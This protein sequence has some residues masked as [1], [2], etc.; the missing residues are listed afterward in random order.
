MSAATS[1]T[2]F[3]LARA[4]LRSD[5]LMHVV[6]QRDTG[7]LNPV[8]GAHP[9][10]GKVVHTWER[11]TMD[12]AALCSDCASIAAGIRG[13]ESVEQGLAVFLGGADDA[14]TMRLVEVAVDAIRSSGDLRDPGD[15]LVRSVSANGVVVP[16]VGRHTRAGLTLV[17]GGR[18]LAAARAAGVVTVPMLVRDIDGQQAVIDRLLENL[19]RE[20]LDPIAQ[21]RA[22][23]DALGMLEVTHEALADGLGVSRPRVSNTIRL[24]EL[25]DHLKDHIAAGR[26]TAA[27]GR[28]LLRLNGH[29]QAQD[30]LADEIL[31]GMTS[32]DA[33]TAARRSAVPAAG[34]PLADV[35]ELLAGLLDA[36]VKVTAGA[37]RSR[38]VIEVP[39]DEADRI[40][41]L[42]GAPS[43]V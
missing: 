6:S 10:R 32:K 7:A 37:Q 5:A 29:Q 22:Y 14:P 41:G 17:S 13:V 23:V 21:A 2:R 27:H 15:E 25:P 8:C 33:E 24:L 31:A 20:D 11:P 1:S 38:F 28:A 40:I 26:M 3:L 9:V 18:R 12:L 16:L 43:V 39:N 4:G 34:V 19:H 36:T 30:E 35:A 42:L